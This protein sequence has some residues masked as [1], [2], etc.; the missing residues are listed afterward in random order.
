MTTDNP[1]QSP[2]ADVLAASASPSG[3]DLQPARRVPAAR[4]AS[5]IGDAFSATA[6]GTAGWILFAL[7][8]IVCYAPMLGVTF[9]AQSGGNV[10]MVVAG[11]LAYPILTLLW[12]GAM[13]G[14]HADKFGFGGAWRGMLG[15]WKPLLVLG[16]MVGLL[17][18]PALLLLA[19]FDLLSG[20]EAA[21]LQVMEERGIGTIAAVYLAMMAYYSIIAMALWFAPALVTI[22]GVSPMRAIVQSIKAAMRNALP[23][24]IFGLVAI[25]LFIA[26]IILVVIVIGVVAAVT[27]LA[28]SLGEGGA[29]SSTGMIAVGAVSVFVYAIFVI[30]MLAVSCQS[31]YASFRDVFLYGDASAAPESA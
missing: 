1:Y 5:W 14:C 9:V 15:A 12:G 29:G 7:F 10:A 13:A 19:A 22:S 25:V 20:D 17:S 3:A 21:M 30:G 4:G 6:R 2:G 8:W 28:G 16:V 18:L 26:L 24:L 27:G 11:V 31:Q 23:L